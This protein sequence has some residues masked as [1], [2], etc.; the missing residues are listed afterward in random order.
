MNNKTFFAGIDI[1]SMTTKC[2]I[3]DDAGVIDRVVLPTDSAPKVSGVNALETVLAKTGIDRSSVTYIVGTGYGRISLDFF[4]HTATEITCHAMGVRY[5]NP[6]VEGIIDIGGQ[7]SKAIKLNSGG[8]VMDF[9]LNDRCAAGTGRFLEVMAKALNLDLDQFGSLY[10]KSENPCSINSTCIVFAESEVISLSAQ[11]ESK[12]DIAAGLH[13]SIA[14]RVGNMAKR[15]GI[16]NNMAFVGGVAKNMGMKNALE[17]Y[18]G[19]EFVSLST[20]PQFTGALG[21]GVI[22]RNQFLKSREN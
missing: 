19:A 17:D 3:M 5:V 7:D 16:K 2:V 18:M 4:N 1:G 6:D 15:L 13:K 11:G 22:A 10:E 21:A 8:S 9:V 14:K 12:T 20:D